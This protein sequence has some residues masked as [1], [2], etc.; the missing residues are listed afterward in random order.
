[1]RYLKRVIQFQFARRVGIFEE[2]TPPKT[3]EGIWKA[4]HLGNVGCYGRRRTTIDGVGVGSARLN[5]T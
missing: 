5:P 4:T 1:M 3:Y 2:S